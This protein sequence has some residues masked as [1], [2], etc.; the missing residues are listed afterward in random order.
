MSVFEWK[1]KCLWDTVQFVTEA[2]PRCSVKKVFLQISQNSQEKI[3]ARVSFLIKLQ[4]WGP[5]LYWK[6][7][8]DTSAF[9]WILRDFYEHLTSPVAAFVSDEIQNIQKD[10]NTR[11][12]R[13]EVWKKVREIGWFVLIFI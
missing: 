8:S 13:K 11:I 6:R 7:D 3:C 2:V 9:L 5:Q 1:K 4:P 10:G 12:E